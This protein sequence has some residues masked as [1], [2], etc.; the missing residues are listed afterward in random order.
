L[1]LDT[2]NHEVYLDWLEHTSKLVSGNK[3]YAILNKLKLRR[4]TAKT[5]TSIKTN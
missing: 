1:A 4:I 5:K 3:A 2:S